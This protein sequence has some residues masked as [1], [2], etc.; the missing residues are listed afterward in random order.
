MYT[1]SCFDLEVEVIEN[2]KLK[3]LVK[4]CLKEAPRY[5]Y[6]MPASTTGKY[7]PA[8]CLGE[9]GLIRHT[10]AAVKIAIDLLS[11]EMNAKLAEHKDEIIIALILHD[12]VKKGATGAEYTVL[13][14]PLQA[15]EFVKTIAK[16]TKLGTPAQIKLI[17]SL[18]E[19]HMGQWNT[20]RFGNKVMEKPKTD[21][22][23]FVHMCDY[24]ASR[25][26]LTANID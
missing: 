9:G 10:K 24:L 1:E 14:H 8:Y 17:R 12:S 26:Y 16:K 4:E 6:E 15:S 23:K 2:E 21:A 18:I 19:T 7:H 3:A 11:L 25:K 20:D 22:Q 5:F 13:T